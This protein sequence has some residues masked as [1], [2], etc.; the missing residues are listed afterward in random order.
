MLDWHVIPSPWHVKI[1]TNLSRQ[2]VLALED[3]GFLLQQKEVLSHRRRFSTSAM[4]PIPRTDFHMPLTPD[5]HPTSKFGP[6]C[7]RFLL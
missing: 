2:E 5:N 4:L 3:D 6:T 7:L 1:G